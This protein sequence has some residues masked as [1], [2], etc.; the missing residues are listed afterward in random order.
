[1]PLTADPN[2]NSG[3]YVKGVGR[4]KPGVTIEQAQAGRS[5]IHKATLGCLLVTFP[6]ARFPVSGMDRITGT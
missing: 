2:V 3:Y 5:R 1:M 6:T 4:L